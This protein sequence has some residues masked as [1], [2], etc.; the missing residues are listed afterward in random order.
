[1]STAEEVASAQIAKVNSQASLSDGTP[2]SSPT[3]NSSTKQYEKAI[4]EKTIDEKRHE[5]DG[6]AHLPH[7]EGAQLWI[8]VTV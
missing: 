2:T 7:V 4:K 3:L 8:L 1:M 5:A 6:Q